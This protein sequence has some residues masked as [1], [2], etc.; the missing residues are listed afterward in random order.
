MDAY[1]P[2]DISTWCNAGFTD[3]LGPATTAQPGARLYHGLPFLMGGATASDPARPCL[4]AFD[5]ASSPVEMPIG[6]PALVGQPARNVLFAHRMV[7]PAKTDG[8]SIGSTVAVYRFIYDDGGVA[9]ATIRCDFEIGRFL[10]RPD[11][12]DFMQPRFEGLWEL[13]GSRQTELEQ[14]GAEA[15]YIW[16]WRN[17]EPDRTLRARFFIGGI[18][19]GHADEEPFARDPMRPVRIE[20]LRPE[21]AERE[22]SGGDPRIASENEGCLEVEVDRGFAGYVH[23]LPSSTAD[24]F[25]DDTHKGWGETNNRKNSPAYVEVTATPSATLSV[26]Q[27][28]EEL[29]AVNWGKLQSEGGAE[30]SSRCRIEVI[31]RGRN[32]VHTSVVD[33][34]TGKPIPCRIHYRSPEGVPYAPHGNHAHMS[35]Y[36]ETWGR[37]AGGDVRLGQITY[38][39]IDGTC[40]GW[41]PRGEVIVDVA[42]GFEYEPLRTRVEIGRDQRELELR[43][44]RWRHMN[45]EGWYSGDTHVHFL[46]T[47][48]S[49]LEA[50]GEDVNVVNLLASQ[51][52]HLFSNTDD[53]RGGPVVS[54]DGRTIVYASQENRQHILGHLNLLGLKRPVMPWCSDGPSEA[55]MGGT[56]DAT[57]SDWADQTHSQGGTV[58]IP[59]FGS[60]NGEIASLIATDRAD[61]AEMTSHHAHVHAEYYRY[62]NCGYK[63]PLVGGTDKMAAECPVGLY[64]TYVRI[65]SDEEFTYDGWCMHLRA[66]R[67]FLSSGPII[68][69]TVDGHEVGDTMALPGNGG[70][71]ELVAEA[72]STLPIHRLEVVQQ[73]R[74]V[75]ATEETDGA[76]RLSLRA[77]VD[78]AGHTWFAARVAGPGYTP[79][80]RHYDSVKWGEGRSVMAHTSP[81]YAACGGEWWMFDAETTQYM[82]T[83][84][85]GALSYVGQ[86]P[87]KDPPGTATYHH[88]RADHEEYLQEPFLEAR[89]AIHRRMHKAGIAH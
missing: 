50:T 60:P 45:D 85:D 39:Y 75:A 61:A 73:G 18:T 52:G 86:M 55:E 72:E 48:G 14:G 89:A 5:A 47:M 76:R 81:I 67:T 30:P 12:K 40:Q 28:G 80:V 59:H 26:R 69:F 70:T 64:R 21:D 49:Q 38:A 33:D 53:L 87:R 7:S 29:A 63:L 79:A 2:L 34:D 31:D 19:L 10:A 8:D 15:F 24:E 17:P 83:L 37:N 77:T 16:A 54:P 36:M 68:R 66:G 44:K 4:I 35:N 23:S 51:W 22:C 27:N 43:L 71:V 58:V 84:V 9:E 78:V 42:R 3:M 74:V 11:Q 57:M 88:G 56:L 41:L 1:R 13:A 65:P 62:L 6:P 25:I 82:L 32:W 20:L 46:S